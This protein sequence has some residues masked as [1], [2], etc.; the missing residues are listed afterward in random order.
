MVISFIYKLFW[1]NAP[2]LRF[3]LVSLTVYEMSDNVFAIEFFHKYLYM[4]SIGFM[5]IMSAILLCKIIVLG[6]YLKT[7]LVYIGTMTLPIYVLHQ[8]LLIWNLKRI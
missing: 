6:K 4:I 8:K 1:D 5:G 3:L 7:S 2:F